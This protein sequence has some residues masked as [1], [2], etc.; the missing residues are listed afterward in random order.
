MEMKKN[1]YV[2]LYLLIPLIFAGITI[3]GVFAAYQLAATPE[4]LHHSLLI[5]VYTLALA[6]GCISFAAGLM[7]LRLFLKPLGE[8]MEKANKMPVFSDVPA[9]EAVNITD[10]FSRI[11]QVLDSV[12]NI[13]GKV[14]ARELFP[15]I[16]GPGAAMRQVFTQILKA[17]PTDSTV[18]I[19]GESGTGKELIANSIYKHSLRNNNPFVTINCVAIPEGLLESELFGHEKGAFTGATAQKKGKFELADGGTVFLDEI[20]DMAPATQAKLLRVLQEKKFERVGGSQTITV[21]VRF[22]AATNKNL[23]EMIK[24]GAFREDLFYRLNVLSIHLPP[25]R[26]R[27]EDIPFLV[28]HFIK[29]SGKDLKMHHRVMQA[30]IG[31][32][33]PGNVRELRNIIERAAIFAENTIEEIHLPPEMNGLPNHQNSSAR[34]DQPLDQ[35]LIEIEKGMII[36]AISRAGGVQARAANLLGINQRSLWHRVKKYNIDVSTLKSPTEQKPKESNNVS[37]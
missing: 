28:E 4:K 10:D 34:Q 37:A 26:E 11:N 1:F 20:G 36:E 14:E 5:N 25:L 17:A 19:A 29:E 30:L 18:L 9:D 7:I 31:Y 15:E 6:I 2:T 16:I 35:K 3:L 13:L 8:F 12:A 32:G 24:T 33:W 21:D 22:I 27:M 23:A